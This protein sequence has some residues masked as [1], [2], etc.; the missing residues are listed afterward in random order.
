MSDHHD[1]DLSPAEERVRS[2][3]GGLHAQPVPGDGRFAGRV[4][5]TARWQ[6]PLRRTLVSIGTTADAIAGGVRSLMGRRR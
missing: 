2:L 6:R 3:L 1:D 5:R 4:G